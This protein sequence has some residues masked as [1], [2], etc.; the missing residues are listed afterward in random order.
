MSEQ[1]HSDEVTQA[2]SKRLAKLRS[3]PVDLSTFDA[4]LKAAL[5]PSTDSSR[6]HVLLWPFVS[7]LRAVAASLVVGAL[8]AA[9]VLLSSSSPALAT[10]Q[11]MADI[12]N[13]AVDRKN[14]PT[15]VSTANEAREVLRR[16]WPDAPV[17]P[18]VQDL[19]LMHCCV[20]EIGRKQMACVTF[21]VEEQPVTLAFASSR[22]VRS[23]HGET[24]VIDGQSFVVGSADGVNMVMSERGGTWMCLMGKLSVERLSEIARTIR[25]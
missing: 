4:R 17:V 2:I 10:P 24:K 13:S 7:P 14:H 18:E 25:D 12:Y 16:K 23:P 15:T 21:L 22:D 6:P 5:P 19:Q 11:R 3:R 1:D 8:L 20:H 9:V